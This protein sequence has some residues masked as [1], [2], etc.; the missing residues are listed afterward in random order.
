MS[1]TH[2][3]P[4]QLE[5]IE[6]LLARFTALKQQYDTLK[7]QPNSTAQRV[8]EH[9]ACVMLQAPTGIGKTLMACELM[10]RFSAQ[11]VVLWFW[12]APFAGLV[13]QAERALKQQAPALT[14]LSI[15]SDRRPDAL[16][17]GAVFV[18]TWQ[19]VAAR[20]REARLARTTGD[21]GIAVED[22]IDAARA[23]G[24]RV[25][26]IVDEAHHGFVRATEASRFFRTALAPDYVLLMS[27]TPRDEDAARFATST[28]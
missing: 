19:T 22:L 28:G 26:V 17:P 2:P 6:A 4:F 27:A 13:G 16:M 18:L 23:R 24:F 1:R 20:T 15:E 25:G 5:Q 9:N 21:A 12:F 10:N 3:L 14:Q 11:E 7:G 8:R